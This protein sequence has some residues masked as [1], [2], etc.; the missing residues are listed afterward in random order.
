MEQVTAEDREAYNLVLWGTAATNSLIADVTAAA[1]SFPDLL[2]TVTSEDGELFSAADHV[3]IG[4]YPSPFTSNGKYV[5]LNSGFTFREGRAFPTQPTLLNPVSHCIRI[6]RKQQRYTTDNLHDGR[7]A[8]T[9]DDY[10]NSMQ[11]PKLPDWAIVAVGPDTPPTAE[12]PGRIET[13]GFF[14]EQW[15]LS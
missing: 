3:A 10:T 11:N 1:S 6:G 13:C 7:C 8:H 9:T 5:L 4:C 15:Q 2:G 14:D 12:S